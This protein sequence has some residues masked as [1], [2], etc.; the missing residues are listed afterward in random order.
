VVLAVCLAVTAL[1]WALA[2]R[3]L[4]ERGAERMERAA[5]HAAM[6]LTARLRDY[7]DVVRAASGFWA[8]SE[9]VEP[10]EFRAF[11]AQLDYP[12]RDPAFVSLAFIEPVPRAQVAAWVEAREREGQ[13]V[14]TPAPGADTELFLIR[15]FAPPP[16]AGTSIG[17]DAGKVALNRAVLEEA[18]QMA[19]A[20]LAGPLPLHYFPND[21][22]FALQYPVFTGAAGSVGTFRGW[23]S[24][25]VRLRPLME[26]A[27]VGSDPDLSVELHDGADSGAPSLLYFAGGSSDSWPAPALAPLSLA[28]R[29]FTLVV[30]PRPGFASSS[31]VIRPRATIATGLLA[32]ALLFGIVWTLASTRRRAVALAETMTSSLRE[33]ERR[34]QVLFEQNLAG[35]YRATEGGRILECN[36]AFARIFG[37]VSRR[38]ML[39]D[40]AVA[41]YERPDERA[42]FVEELRTKGTLLNHEHR[43][44]RRDGTPVWT[45]EYVTL[46]AEDG[47]IEGTIV[48]VSETKRAEDAL[49]ASE[50]RYRGVFQQFRDGIF[51]VDPST[52]KLLETNTS[53]QKTLGYTADEL[54]GMV[55]YDLVA[56]EPAGVDANIARA[57]ADSALHVGERRYRRKDGSTVGMDVEAFRFEEAGRPLVF[58]L[59]RNLA[60]RQ[61]LEDQL[62][63]AQKM[64]AV[65]RLAGGVAHDFNN[66][67]TAILGYSDMVLTDEPPEDVRQ[68]V[69]EIRKAAERAAALTG[70]LLAF[71]RKQVL[72]P[73]ILEL[74][75]V[76]RNVDAMLKRVLRENVKVVHDA[77]PNLWRVKADPGQ[78][79]QVLMNLAVNASDAMS[80][81]GALT[82]RT[83]NATLGS[84]EV[85]GVP[86][87]HAGMYVVLEVSDTGHGM[88]AAILAHAFEPFFT[89]KERGKGTGLGLATVYGIVKQSGGYIDVLSEPGKGATFRI[90]LPRVHGAADSPSNV[91]PRPAPLRGSE[92][93]L[94]VE[95]EESVRRLT[96]TVLRSR[97]YR[98][99]AAPTAEAALEISRTNA[100]RIH[101]L[102][103]DVVLPGMNGRQLGE[104]LVRERPGLALLYS[105]GYF[106][107]REGLEGTEPF[108]RKPFTPDGLLEK[109]R[110]T[111]NK[112]A[113]RAT[114]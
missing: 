63:Q 39:E 60:D 87:L 108:L 61:L 68:P 51:F 83:R 57:A 71:S 95:D 29:T 19:H 88:D 91:S 1:L 78:V 11:V 79:E 50:E 99:L 18:R 76:V 56:E 104:I 81:G 31:G 9:S 109:V 58:V 49:R 15:H 46:R 100:A 98:V 103:T 32:S 22:G 74:N 7:E 94:L 12:R 48:D 47:V 25:M 107:T 16:P 52:K 86:M 64:E 14:Q 77:D 85:R 89:T 66:L 93:I 42:R 54:R 44:R 80:D 43:Y 112:A 90:Y 67:L 5:R 28:G 70:Q 113:G 36:D 59:V 33:S 38:E 55:L 65:G 17:A 69:E 105:S 96:E 62:R 8:G 101:L 24:I 75:E 3:A 20:R 73:R 23:M 111:L 13:A 40:S 37:Y 92:T 21:R 41:L 6:G 30:R 106:E 53:L 2:E 82:I 26:E 102:L 97:G 84:G 10:A 72:Q 45:L 4:E 114:D 110:S 27:L 34:Y 35:I